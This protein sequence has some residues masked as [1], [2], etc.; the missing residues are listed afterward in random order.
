MGK[1]SN[2]APQKAIT[3]AIKVHFA[4]L[5]YLG[6]TGFDGGMKWY[7][8]TRSGDCRL[9]NHFGRKINWQQRVCSRCLVEVQ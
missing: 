3:H 4:L 9:H 5:H 7:V 1:V 2:F 6:L 8:S